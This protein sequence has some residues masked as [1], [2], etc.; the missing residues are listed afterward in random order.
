M[1]YGLYLS[2]AG[3]LVQNSKLD[4]LANNMANVNTPGFKPDQL[5][6]KERQ[7]EAIEDGPYSFSN[8]LMNKIGG[9]L[10]FERT[11]I[12]FSPGPLQQTGNTF[13]LAIN[14]DGFFQV[15]GED[16]TF[17]TRAG[18]FV[19]D[20]QGRLAMPGG[21]Y[22]VLGVGGGPVQVP[23]GQVTEVRTDGR[24]VVDGRVTGQVV[25]KAFTPEQLRALRKEG[26]NLFD[27]QGQGQPDDATA[28]IRSGFVEGST[29]NPI[30]M[31]TELINTQRNFD[32][33][34]R[35]VQMQDT[36]LETN[37]QVGRAL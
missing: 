25:V 35:L 22:R 28:D 16:G 8:A 7:A 18:N 29:V 31:M 12:D 32:F 13:D 30:T 15:Q 11:A 1:N 34:M 21:K 2:A 26:E 5:L 23:P 17:Y 33:N 6:V 10:L 3:G 14:G 19:V 9:G 27:F 24:V 20:S 36:L 4:I 37:A